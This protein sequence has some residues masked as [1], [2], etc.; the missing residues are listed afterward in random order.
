MSKRILTEYWPV[1]IPLRQ[2][3]WA[4]WYEDSDEED[5][6]GFGETEAEAIKDLETRFEEFENF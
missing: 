6:W 1:P 5:P 3:D 2:F 4:A